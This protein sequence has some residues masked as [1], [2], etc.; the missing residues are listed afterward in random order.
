MFTALSSKLEP[1]LPDCSLDYLEQLIDEAEAARFLAFSVRSLQGWRY[2][3]GGPRFVKI[4]RTV[5]YRR[6]DLQ[7]WAEAQIRVSTADP[8]ASAQ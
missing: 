4:G 5:R 2:R 3:G 1:A 6:R 7:A 8:G